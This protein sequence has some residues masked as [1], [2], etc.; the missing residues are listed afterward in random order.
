[1]Q[2][3]NSVYSA[4]NCECKQSTLTAKFGCNTA[5]NLHPVLQWMDFR[6]WFRNTD[7]RP[8]H[9]SIRDK[10]TNLLMYR[11]RNDAAARWKTWDPWRA[12][13]RIIPP[14]GTSPHSLRFTGNVMVLLPYPKPSASEGQRPE[15]TFI[16]DTSTHPAMYR[17]W[18]EA[19]VR[20]SRP[21]AQQEPRAIA[22]FH[23]G[24]ILTFWD[25]LELRWSSH[26][27]TEGPSFPS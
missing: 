12:E 14:S 25:V 3:K 20:G 8:N 11:S 23:Q 7:E 13:G 2:F 15:H 5:V 24:Q 1:M 6:D 27:M 16:R 4:V 9:T 18:V 26:G 17:N 10:C 22:C 19:D 21:E